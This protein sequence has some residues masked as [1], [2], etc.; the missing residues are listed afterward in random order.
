MSQSDSQT[1]TRINEKIK[2]P[3]LYRVIYINDNQT[4]M[5]FVVA[6]LMEFFNY[7]QELAT[8]ITLDIHQ[9]GSACVAVLPFEIAEQKGI[10]VTLSARQNNFP[11]QVK[12]E[13]ETIH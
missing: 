12:L 1:R 6:S 9:D 7:S 5:D 8:Q 3:P 2:E 11:L 4:H 13:P 10:E